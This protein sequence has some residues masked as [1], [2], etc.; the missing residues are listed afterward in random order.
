MQ[1]NGGAGGSRAKSEGIAVGS[2]PGTPFD[3]DGEIERQKLLGQLPLKR[4][5]LCAGLFVVDVDREGVHPLVGSK[6]N[7]AELGLKRVA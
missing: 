6:T 5:N 3:D 4:L 7:G 1:L 2:S